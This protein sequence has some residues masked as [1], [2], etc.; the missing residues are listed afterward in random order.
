MATYTMIGRTYLDLNE[1]SAARATKHFDDNRTAEVV[2]WLRGGTQIVFT[3][4]DVPLFSEAF[5][6]H[7]NA[8]PAVLTARAPV[9]GR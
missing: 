8:D 3:H 6:K 9:Q 4:E 5:A 2:V 1:V 7:A